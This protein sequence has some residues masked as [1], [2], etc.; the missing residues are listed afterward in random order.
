VPLPAETQR[1]RVKGKRV[2]ILHDL[3]TVTGEYGAV[4]MGT[5]TDAR[6]W[7]GGFVR[8]S[9]SQET[10]RLLVQECEVPDHELLVVLLGTLPDGGVFLSFARFPQR[11]FSFSEIG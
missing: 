11:A 5:A 8:R 4:C 7:E 9:W 2:K 1:Q 10:C 6:R 3:V